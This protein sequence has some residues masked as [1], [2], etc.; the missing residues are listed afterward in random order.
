MSESSTPSCAASARSQGGGELK[1]LRVRHLGRLDYE[2]VWQAMRDFTDQ[3]SPD[4]VD[5]L[6]L[7][8]HPPV[9]TQG[10]AG[11]PEHL[12]NPGNIPIVQTDRGGQ[13][14]YHGPGQVVAY[15]LL[16]LKRSGLGVR[17]L[18]DR[19]EQAMIDVLAGWG[20]ESARRD[21]APGVYVGD[22]KIG[23]IGLKIRHERSYH[24]LAFNVDM[25][26]APFSL[27]NP[28]GYAGLAM[29]RVIDHRP[30]TSWQE[31]AET[32]TTAICALLGYHAK[33]PENSALP[34]LSELKNGEA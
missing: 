23:S 34:S 26:L 33:K 30:G 20:V 21:G 5:E 19:L 7:V 6:W 24:G 11:K 2:P 15:P 3:R 31:T 25:D 1:P 14:T 28:C 13:V 16:D 18:V 4:T 29:T 9:F 32:L 22:A 10:L 17:C 27:I 12:L 8:E